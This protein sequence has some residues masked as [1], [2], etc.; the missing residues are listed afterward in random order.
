M[1]MVGYETL[2]F[3]TW[4]LKVRKHIK[5]WPP[6]CYTTK[7]NDRIRTFLFWPKVLKWYLACRCE[8]WMGQK[9]DSLIVHNKQLVLHINMKFKFSYP[10]HLATPILKHIYKSFWVTAVITLG[11][12]HREKQALQ[13]FNELM[14]CCRYAL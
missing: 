6:K 1:V 8:S 7:K 4:E 2:C 13:D 12:P 3:K 11:M 5:F 14:P 10:C 9:E